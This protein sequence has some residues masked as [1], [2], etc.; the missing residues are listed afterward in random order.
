MSIETGGT[1]PRQVSDDDLRW[2][3]LNDWQ[4]VLCSQATPEQREIVYREA[5]RVNMGDTSAIPGMGI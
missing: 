2:A 3:G 5:I 1:V 4:V